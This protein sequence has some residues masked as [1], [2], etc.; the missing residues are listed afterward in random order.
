MVVRLL[1]IK[2][3]D[4]LAVARKL[5]RVVALDFGETKEEGP[6]VDEDGR[7]VRVE[8]A[9]HVGALPC[10]VARIRKTAVA[11]VAKRSALGE[12]ALQKRSGSLPVLA[13]G[14]RRERRLAHWIVCPEGCPA[15]IWRPAKPRAGYLKT[16]RLHDDK[17][18]QKHR[19]HGGPFGLDLRPRAQGERNGKDEE[20]QRRRGQRLPSDELDL[21][22]DD[23]GGRGDEEAQRE[24]PQPPEAGQ[25][26]CA[27]RYLLDRRSAE[28][29]RPNGNQDE[30]KRW[31]MFVQFLKAWHE[32]EET[33]ERSWRLS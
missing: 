23:R 12:L 10:L 9:G 24:E 28:E 26:A 17:A 18:D 25:T 13:I 22:R 1:A 31:G 14:I 5:A 15:R 19:H 7:D 11:D 20:G 32:V 33:M 29:R 4:E 6:S 3:I 8:A 2:G 30:G 21:P 27:A 16:H